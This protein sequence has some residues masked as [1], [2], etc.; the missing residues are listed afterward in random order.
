[1]QLSGRATWIA[2]RR[3]LLAAA[4]AGST[5]SQTAP[6]VTGVGA[7]RGWAQVNHWLKSIGVGLGGMQKFVE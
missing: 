7:D 4:V 2:W 1:M 3:S 5:P 6:H